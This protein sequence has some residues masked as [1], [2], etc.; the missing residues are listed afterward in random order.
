MNLDEIESYIRVNFQPLQL[1]QPSDTIKQSITNVIR[2]INTNSAYRILKMYDSANVISISNE[3]KNVVQVLPSKQAASAGL[4]DP[5]WTLLGIQTMNYLTS[6][7]IAINEAYKNYQAYFGSD[8][9]YTFEPSQDPSSEGKLYCQNIPSSATQVAVIGTKRILPD[10]DILNEQILDH[11]LRGSL[12]QVK[13]NEG[14][15]LRKANIIGIQ[16]DGQQLL[17]E[18][19]IE[20]DTLKEEIHKNSRYFT[21]S[22]RI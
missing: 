16:N 10:E 7:F 5:T 17:D 15:V 11:V 2:W 18:G 19:K 6:D 4:A 8:F 14:N 21:F 1:S 22:K 9:Q 12:A 13:M 3:F 20:W